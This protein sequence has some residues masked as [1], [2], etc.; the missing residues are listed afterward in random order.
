MLGAVVG[1]VVCVLVTN[2]R[3]ASRIDAAL[4][5][6]GDAR[7]EAARVAAS[8]D[9]PGARAGLARDRLIAALGEL[10]ESMDAA[11]GEW[12]QCALPEERVAAAERE[13]HRALTRLVHTLRAGAATG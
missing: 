6:V 3:A 2:R 7:D 11:S 5:R 9:V 12:W 10:R 4:D 8:P 13:G 1:V